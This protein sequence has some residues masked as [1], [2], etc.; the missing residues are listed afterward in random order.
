MF[1]YNH[2]KFNLG[3]G[4]SSLPKVVFVI[5]ILLK[6]YEF[7]KQVDYICCG[8]SHGKVGFNDLIK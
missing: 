8:I 2:S 6:S 5:V 1:V 3:Y 4:F 7:F